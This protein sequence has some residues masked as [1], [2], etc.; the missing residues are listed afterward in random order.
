MLAFDCRER[1]RLRREE[2][3]MESQQD[4]VNREALRVLSDVELAQV[5]EDGGP[6]DLIHAAVK[7]QRERVEIKDAEM[8]F[9]VHGH[10][11]CDPR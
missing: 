11:P 7:I 3:L 4:F 2:A 9:R 1:G 5:I 8:Y 10:Y 6:S